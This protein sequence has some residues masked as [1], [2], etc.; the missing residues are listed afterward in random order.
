MEFKT[1]DFHPLVEAGVKAA[2]YITPTPIQQQAIP[3]L[4]N[5]RD[6]MGLAQT[7]TG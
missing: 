4:L 3:L 6:I 2:G 5:G 7:G 1:F